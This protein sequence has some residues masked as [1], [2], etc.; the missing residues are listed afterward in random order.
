MMERILAKIPLKRSGDPK[1]IAYAAV[2]FSSDECR[3]MTGQ[4]LSANGGLHL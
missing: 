3:Y 1:E 2:F 4:V